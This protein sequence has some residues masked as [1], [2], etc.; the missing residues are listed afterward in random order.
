MEEVEK[1]RSEVFELRRLNDRLVERLQK[2]ESKCAELEEDVITLRNRLED[3]RERRNELDQYGRRENLRYVKLGPYSSREN[4]T[5]CEEKVLAVIQE[6]LKLG[7]I[8][9]QHISVAHRVGQYSR[10]YQRQ[11]I[12]RFVSRRHRTEII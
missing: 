7:R 9:R 8:T 11:V 1:L 2:S 10:G 3:E 4:M 5:Q 6:K 12:V